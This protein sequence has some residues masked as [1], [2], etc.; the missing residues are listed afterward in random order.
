MVVIGFPWLSINDEISCFL[1]YFCC[2]ITVQFRCFSLVL[3]GKFSGVGL[4]D[5][6][7]YELWVNLFSLVFYR[8][9]DGLTFDV[10]HI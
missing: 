6:R 3:A 4:Q 9:S 1:I 7:Q 8:D 2:C 10:Q 5:C